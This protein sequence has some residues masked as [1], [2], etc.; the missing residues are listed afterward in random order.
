MWKNL[1]VIS[2][3][4]ALALMVACSESNEDTCKKFDELC[5]AGTPS[6]S[7][8]PDAGTTTTVTVSKCDPGGFD[9]MDNA[10]EVKDCINDAKDCNAATAC[11]LKAKKK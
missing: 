5:Q 4:S 9:Q 7:S 6:T 11:A 10:D 8:D 3:L 2:V 1:A